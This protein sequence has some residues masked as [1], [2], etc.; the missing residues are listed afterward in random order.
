MNGTV[1]HLREPRV[2]SS[3]V[4][5]AGNVNFRTRSHCCKWVSIREWNSNER[6][7][8]DRPAEE[9]RGNRGEIAGT[10]RDAE[11][12]VRPVRFVAFA[13]WNERT[14]ER[15][16]TLTPLGP[17]SS[18]FNQLPT[19]CPPSFSSS[20]FPSFSSSFPFFTF[21]PRGIQ[22][23]ASAWR[24]LPPPRHEGRLWSRLA[25]PTWT[26]RSDE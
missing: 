22:T 15:T 6:N 11:N 10:S 23:T 2:S 13:W 26:L 18:S 8:R 4:E 20:P 24:F 7:R 14:N 5:L 12:V 17:V 16:A 3:P 19:T 9:S 21:L 1:H 25:T